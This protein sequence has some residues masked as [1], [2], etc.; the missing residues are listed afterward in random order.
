M[1]Y[2][3]RQR[4][5]FLLWTAGLISYIGNWMLAIARPVV[6]YQLTGSTLAVGGVILAAALPG[7]LLS[8]FAGVFVD[9]WER[10]RTM[11]IL[12]LL[13][14][15]S[16]LPLM[17]VQTADHL[18]IV[19]LVTFVQATLGQFFAPAENAM[20][21]LLVDEKHLVSANALNALNNNLARLIGPAIGGLTLSTLGLSGIVQVD[22]LTYAL[23]AL[24]IALISVTSQP[25]S[26][27]HPDKLRQFGRDWR[28]G[29]R[30]VRHDHM[31][32]ILFICAALM[33]VGEGAI[34][35]LFV[36]FVTDVLHGEALQ[37]GWLMSAQAVGG[38]IGGLVIGW[39]GKHVLPL[40]LFI[41]SSALFGVIDLVIF[42]YSLFTE[43]LWI[44]LILFV[45]VG[46][47]AIGLGTGFDTLIQSRT[48]DQFRGRVSGSLNTVFAFFYIVGTGIASTLGETV[49][50]LPTINLQGSNYVV[51]ALLCFIALRRDWMND[52]RPAASA[53][54]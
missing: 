31:L 9:R 28:E 43:G 38:I 32:L 20:L 4:D 12:N 49:G 44:A 21:P 13:L 48:R 14:G 24:L 2:A 51:I 40:R 35:T 7:V 23:A 50:V 30:V 39:I 34:S 47:P 42:N 53:G 29:L 18:W 16:I 27:T 36:P 54:D 1:L 46:I 3:L 11:V 6:V 5:F 26:T 19:Y 10:R 52:L 37:L 41:V 15:L 33:A 8:S 45:I 17:L 25:A 22:A